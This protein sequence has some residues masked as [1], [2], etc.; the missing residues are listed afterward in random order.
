ML[1]LA[2]K[3]GRL[4]NVALVT[5]M[6]DRLVS[7]EEGLK[8]EEMFKAKFWNEMI[9]FGASVARIEDH[10]DKQA[11]LGIVEQIMKNNG[12]TLKIQEETVDQQLPLGET[13]AGKVILD[14][15]N[16][17]AQRWDED[18]AK[19]NEELRQAR[20]KADQEA[21]LMQE[22][23]QK[24]KKALE[25]QIQLAAVDR[26]NLQKTLSG[27]AQENKQLAEILNRM[28]LENTE[29]AKK[30]K[31]GE[32]QKDKEKAS[33]VGSNTGQ[34][35]PITSFKYMLW[36]T[37]HQTLYTNSPDRFHDVAFLPTDPKSIITGS[38][39]G[40]VQRWDMATG[41][42]KEFTTVL[43]GGGF[44][45]E[46]VSVAPTPDGKSVWIADGKY[47]VWNWV[48]GRN[49]NTS[50]YGDMAK[51]PNL[52]SRRAVVSTDG[53]LLSAR[54]QLWYLP[55]C[56]QIG[57][58]AGA[59]EPAAFSPDG[60]LVAM[61]SLPLTIWD[62]ATCQLRKKI[63]GHSA[64][65]TDVQFS[66]DGRLVIS[67]SIDQTVRLWDWANDRLHSIIAD[68]AYPIHTVAVAPN[69]RL[70]VYA[71]HTAQK[72]WVWDI[73]S[74]CRLAEIQDYFAGG[75]GRGIAFSPDSTLLAMT[76][77]DRT[78]GVSQRF[79]VRIWRLSYD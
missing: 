72:A 17:L 63:P 45:T 76:G 79:L 49:N 73:A 32:N 41:V 7:K 59:A 33:P 21:K 44:S 19:L 26:A 10:N 74:K 47:S 18:I 57:T 58:M 70:L 34:P 69:G 38:Y 46:I 56:R 15:V 67:T 75:T 22:L 60:S 3:D 42:S 68:S 8:T 77:L 37:L 31:D 48:L 25:D 16:K 71:S 1:E 20:E 55:T 35:A 61:G 24:E 6:W 29:R 27:L 2:G 53:K 11:Y 43:Y 23:L 66:P 4:R 30:E 14:Y 28:T 54:D 40:I 36:H 52:I 50:T 62:T 5:T 65:L 12:V 39:S 51:L 9:S 13:S 78:P 64:Y